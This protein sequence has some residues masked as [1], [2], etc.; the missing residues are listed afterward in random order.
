MIELI[1]TILFDFFKNMGAYMPNL[2]GGLL[3]LVVGLL[4]GS[5]VKQLILTVVTFS[6]IDLLFHKTKLIKKEEVNIWT[7]VLSEIL[8]WMLIIV[9]LVPALEVWGLSRA[10]AVVNQILFYLP[11]V[12]VAVVIAFVGILASNLMADLVRHSVKTMG[13][14]ASNSLAVFTRGTIMFFTVLVVLNQL[15]VAQDLIRIL[16]TGIVAM[17]SI[18]GG[19]AFGLGGKDLAKEILEDLKSKMK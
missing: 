17:L 14:T 15:G 19:L 11:N 6:K 16:F 9:F 5:I 8:K 4:I 3:I 7:E 2:F 18:S 10:T 12:V 1:N 13:S